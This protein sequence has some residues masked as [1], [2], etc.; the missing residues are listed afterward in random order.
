MKI[1]ILGGN[2]FVGSNLATFLASFYSVATASR[3]VSQSNLYF[4]LHQPETF[5][6]CRDYDVVINCIVDYT[7]TVEGTIQNDL[8]SKLQ[9]I[10]YI[11]TLSLHYIEISSISAVAEN[12]YLSAYNFSKFLSEEVTYYAAQ[13][14]QFD[15]SLLRFAQII[16][17]H[18][19][20]RKSQGAFNYFVDCFRN[21]TIL[22]VFGNPNVP[23]SYMPISILVQ[24]VHH[25][26]KAKILGSH[27]VI[28]PDSYSANDLIMAFQK[29]IPKPESEFNYD[30]SRFAFEY[31]I[32][33]CSESFVTLLADFSCETTFKN[34][35]YNEEI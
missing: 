22:N 17:E 21:K 24:T 28:M 4:D 7:H 27:Q 5:S 26:I 10:K 6:L 18:G 2:G 11:S 3:S 12:K 20:S 9:F 1:L 8:Q 35:L 19:L 23:R 14:N 16:D 33:S 31:F 15:F 13:Q 34:C 30:A 25:C 32:P 29:Y